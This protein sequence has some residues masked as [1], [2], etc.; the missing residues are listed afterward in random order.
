MDDK[1]TWG[2]ARANSGRKPKEHVIINIR[3]SPKTAVWIKEYAREMGISQGA[4]VDELVEK[5]KSGM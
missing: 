4:V 3:V 5:K 1:K 2:G